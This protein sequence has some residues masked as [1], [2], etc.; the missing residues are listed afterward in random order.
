[1]P[2]YFYHLNFELY[3]TPNP[4]P[5][6]HT[7]NPNP[8]TSTECGKQIWLPPPTADIFASSWPSHERTFKAKS[9]QTH[10]TVSIPSSSKTSVSRLSESVQSVVIDCGPAP[11][12]HSSPTLSPPAAGTPTRSGFEVSLGLPR[13]QHAAVRD[14]RFG[15][16]VLRVRT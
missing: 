15:V 8:T 16:L 6:T 9:L 13:D 11:V 3:P 4:E 2:T 14:W 12:K 1:M 10:T 7:P 5:E